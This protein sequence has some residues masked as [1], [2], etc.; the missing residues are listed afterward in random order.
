MAFEL[1]KLRCHR[2]IAPGQLLDRHVLR[3]IVR[4]AQVAVRANQRILGL[5]QMIDRLVDLGNRRLVVPR[6]QIVVLRERGLDFRISDA[7]VKLGLRPFGH[8]I[9]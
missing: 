3:L 2:W 1:R 4:E 8:L 9:V 7:S 6:G 5:L